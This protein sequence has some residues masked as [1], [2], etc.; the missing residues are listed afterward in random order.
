MLSFSSSLPVMKDLPSSRSQGDVHLFYSLFDRNTDLSKNRDTETL[1]YL[2][3]IDDLLDYL[4]DIDD[5]LDVYEDEWGVLTEKEY[6]GAVENVNA[7]HKKNKTAA[8][9]A[10]S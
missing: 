5:L 6:Q 1:N 3:D 4:S 9:S 8:F 7:I 10:V 2:S